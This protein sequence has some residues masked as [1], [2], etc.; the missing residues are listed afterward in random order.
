LRDKPFA[1]SDSVDYPHV[2]RTPFTLV[3]ATFV[4]TATVMASAGAFWIA[5]GWPSGGSAVI[6]AALACGLCATSPRPSRLAW[7]MAI[8][9]A[10]SV[11][12]GCTMMRCVYPNIDSFPL[13]CVALAPLVAGGTFVAARRETSGFGSGFLVFFCLLAGPDNV[14]DYAPET[15]LNNGLAAVIALFAA[16]LCFAAILPPHAKW[17]VKKAERELRSQVARAC[18]E[19][20]DG[21]NHRFHASTHDLMYQMRGLLE[22]RS[23]AHRRALRWMLATLEIGQ[24]VIDLREALARIPGDEVAPRQWRIA[25]R[26]LRQEIAL[27]FIESNETQRVR[28]IAAVA[29]ALETAQLVLASSSVPHRER[30]EIKRIV[31]SMHSIRT[32][33]LDRDAPFRRR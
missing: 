7:Q 18:E 32:A 15:L 8:G 26:T 9:A 31:A 33:L 19:R 21:L 1:L 10:A 20:L 17:L 22:D 4:R 30:V 16:A 27:L 6:A 29:A 28:A 24:A 13:L 5:T 2:A 25:V 11:L 3:G 14:I 12:I 23:R